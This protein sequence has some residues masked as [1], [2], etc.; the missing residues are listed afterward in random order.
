[1]KRVLIIL[2]ALGILCSCDKEAEVPN[3]QLEISVLD[4]EGNGA[5]NAEVSVYLSLAGFLDQD[6]PVANGLTDASGA[7]T[8]HGLKPKQMYYIDVRR[9]NATNWISQI[10]SPYIE[11]GV[12][13]F[14]TV[15]SENWYSNLSNAAG[16]SWSP[17]FVFID[18]VWYVYVDCFNDDQYLFRKNLK[19]SY[20]NHTKCSASDPDFYTG[21]WFGTANQVT[22]YSDTEGD[23][24]LSFKLVESDHAYFLGELRVSGGDVLLVRFE[25]MGI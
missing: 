12:N 1:M 8:F 18:D 25:K 23:A 21:E 24:G 13:A 3:T 22:I 20:R 4:A 10:T 14:T 15:I 19:M 16:I 17:K 7:I 9:V 11:E 2:F 6:G 5:S